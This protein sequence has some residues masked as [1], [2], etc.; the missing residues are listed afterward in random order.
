MIRGKP[1]LPVV[2]PRPAV[3]SQQV[4]ET[5]LVPAVKVAMALLLGGLLPAET[6]PTETPIVPALR[7]SPLTK[8]T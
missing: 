3:G 4:A 2:A 6:L 1:L 5:W 8:V 7:I